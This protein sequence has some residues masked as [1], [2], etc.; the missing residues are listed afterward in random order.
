MKQKSPARSNSFVFVFSEDRDTTYAIQSAPTPD[1]T[2]G[3]T[4][5]GS[6]KK[7]VY[8]PSNKIE[9]SPIIVQFLLGE[10]LEEYIKMYKWMLRIK[11]LNTSHVLGEAK[12]CELISLDS[13]NQP[14]YRFIYEDCFPT[15]ISA[16]NYSS[17]GESI[18]LSF[19]VTLRYNLFSIRTKDNQIIDDSYTG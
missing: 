4:M 14:M 1:L 9:T 15:N 8:V 16:I 6:Q 19:D 11:N 13:Q 3:E 7:D 17:Q 10:D 2:V 5:F 18:P 12:T